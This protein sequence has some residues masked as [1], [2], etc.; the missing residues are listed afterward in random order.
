MWGEMCFGKGYD[1]VL[2]QAAA[3]G[4]RKEVIRSIDNGGEVNA[5]DGWG[6]TALHHAVLLGLG[7]GTCVSVLLKYGA[8]VNVQDDSGWTPLCRA[9]FWGN[10]QCA[11]RLLDAG[12]DTE[13]ETMGLRRALH[14]AA[15]RGQYGCV[16]LLVERGAEVRCRALASVIGACVAP[17]SIGQSG[18]PEVATRNCM[19]CLSSAR[20]W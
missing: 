1:R 17:Y 7:N 10:Y 8:R 16:K 20:Y 4:M 11:L 3:L 15:Y 18:K 2:W 19:R 14:W 13:L 12:A 6:R 5:M 9:V